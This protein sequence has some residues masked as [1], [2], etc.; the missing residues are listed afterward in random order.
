MGDDSAPASDASV[1]TAMRLADSFLPVGTYTASY[2]IEQYVNEGRIE[3]AGEL[4]ALIEGYLRRIVGPAD[5][6]ALANAHRA[7]AAGDLAGVTEADERLHAA[8]LP[9]EF[10][11]SATKGGHKLLELLRDTD[12]GLF[13]A[14]SDG[15]NG[16]E[17]ANP[18]RSDGILAAYADAVAADETPG[19]Y[20]VALGVVTQAAGID[21]RTACLVGAYGFLTELLGAAQR[22]GRFGHTDIQAQLT[23]LLSVVE[24]IAERYADSDLAEL[25]SFGPLAE[26][27]GMDHERADRRLFMS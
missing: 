11:T 12:P 5:T 16:S 10:R 20:P 6:V 27:M 9:A 7:A 17:H 1:L 18:D 14:G 24:S 19:S 4:G 26:I 2:G 3:T 21:R 23:R 22:L 15:G 25:T 8:T 13:E